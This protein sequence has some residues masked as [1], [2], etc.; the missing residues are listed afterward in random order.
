MSSKSYFKSL[1]AFGLLLFTALMS[2]A[3]GNKLYLGNFSVNDY[4]PV[5]V[6]VYLDNQDPVAALDFT[7]EMPSGLSLLSV[8]PNSERFSIGQQLISNLSTGKVI[9][10][11]WNNNAFVGNSGA[12]LY[13]TVQAKPGSLTEPGS[14]KLSLTNITLSS[15]SGQQFPCDSTSE[16]NVSMGLGTAVLS[17]TESEFY[18]NPSGLKTLSVSLQNDF[19]ALGAQMTLTL[20][21]GWN[22]A[23]PYDAIQLSNRCINTGAVASIKDRGNGVYNIVIATMSNGGQA[24]SGNSGELFTFTVVA[25]NFTAETAT[26]SISNAT[27]SRTGSSAGANVTVYAAN[28]A[29]TA[30]NGLPAYEKAT[31]E[32]ERLRSLLADALNTIAQNAPD[33]AGIYTGEE[34]K[35]QIDALSNA[36]EA[37]YA[38]LTLTPN[39]DEVMAPV[40]DIEKAIA[41]LVVNAELA[42][43]NHK[44]LE[45]ANVEIG[46][47]QNSLNETLEK[48]ASECP[49]VKDQFTG[50]YEQSLIDAL[51]S[52]VEE[53]AEN[54]TLSDQY[55]NLMSTTTT[56]QEAIDKLL[57]DAQAAQKQYEDESDAKASADAVVEQLQKE[58]EAAMQ[59]IA[60][61]CPDVAAAYP[62]TSIDAM[63][64]EL[65]AS[66]ASA[67]E[68]MTLAKNYDSVVTKP[69][70]NISEAIS[71]LVEEAKN[72]QSA[73]DNLVSLYE[74]AKQRISEL[75]SSLDQTLATIKEE[76]PSVA[77][78]FTGTSIQNQINTLS[79]AIE[80]AYKNGTLVNDYNTIMTPVLSIETAIAALL[81]NAR[82]AQARADLD[83]A[84][85]QATS[86]IN[87]LKTELQDALAQIAKDY[88]DVADQYKGTEI[89]AMINEMSSNVLNAYNAGTLVKL[90]PTV[91]TAPAQNIEKAISELLASAKAAQEEIDAKRSANQKAYAEGQALVSSLKDE[92]EQALSTIASSCPDV[93]DEFSG[94]EISESIDKLAEDILNAFN[95]E[96]L[97]DNYDKVT[98]PAAG[99]EK[100]ISELVEAAKA[101]Q[102]E[103]N[104]K[105]ENDQANANAQALIDGLRSK[106]NDALST[107]AS[108]CPDVKDQF[109]GKNI[110][111]EIDNLAKEIE[112][113]YKEGNLADNY[114]TVTAPASGI[115]TA[116][117]DLIAAAQAAQKAYDD[118][119]A[120]QAANQAAYEADMALINELRQQFESA[121]AEIESMDNVSD[122]F[123]LTL[124][125]AAIN[126]ALDAQESKAETALAKVANSG[127][128]QN[129]VDV[130]GIESMIQE[131]L[132][133]AKMPPAGVG[134]IFQDWDESQVK[135]FT[136]DG[137]QVPALQEGQI[138]IVVYPNG[139]AKKV[140]LK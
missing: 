132:E 39:Y 104:D 23:N 58:L 35:T 94:S 20:P 135:I 50:A 42:Q 79:Q 106:L 122:Q 24:I 80:N 12:V 123:N 26:V 51:K 13:L 91:V 19:N 41:Q 96:T 128:Y 57:A 72:A 1:L 69:A 44:A 36:V 33:V 62:S 133:A 136:V 89:S 22:F 21:E 3:Q 59:T 84:F 138:N 87:K 105:K 6:P 5:T 9:V 68:Q 134:E 118:E 43:A 99:I 92:L 120:R 55:D 48:I 119:Q 130:I 116:I 102:E 66:I 56:I 4:N 103:Y 110:S 28:V 11:S 46:A 47:L 67:Y 115:E 38:D 70:A 114:E 2:K 101:A 108:T 129:T 125:E 8:D 109:D 45:E 63:I 34:I 85:E 74:S 100:A 78:Q 18:I 65:K 7:I 71:K 75:Q 54:G 25:D 107:I 15:G 64:E 124:Y 29:A 83:D 113:A 14:Q 27:F 60:K 32:V 76:C 88:P 117:A 17:I 137:K 121:I 77:D 93:K 127:T 111:A 10:A 49:D 86:V 112:N 52:K 90:Y 81:E 37:A 97:A 131:M 126:N 61:E 16:V 73:H 95:N 82:A 40:S 30:I 140:V 53:A 139:K 31:A 98:A